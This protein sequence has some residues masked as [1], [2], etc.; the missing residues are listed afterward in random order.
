MLDCVRRSLAR[1]APSWP[2]ATSFS[3]TVPMHGE[4]GAFARSR[5]HALT[6]ADLS[7]FAHVVARV[8]HVDKAEPLPIAPI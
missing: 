4:P 8:E 5:R 6:F 7:A 1:L 2:T 3:L